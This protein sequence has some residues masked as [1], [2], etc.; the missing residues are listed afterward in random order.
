MTKKGLESFFLCRV[1]S[2]NNLEIND[3]SASFCQIFHFEELFPG[4]IGATGI[5]FMYNFLQGARLSFGY[6]KFSKFFSAALA[7]MNWKKWN[8]F[9]Y[10]IKLSK[11]RPYV[12]GNIDVVGLFFLSMFWSRPTYLMPEP[13]FFRCRFISKNKLEIIELFVI[14]HHCQD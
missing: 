4:L 3:F 6:N 12:S 10:F 14:F 5:L 9:L 11:L 1:I 2:K 8:F 13:K 7:K